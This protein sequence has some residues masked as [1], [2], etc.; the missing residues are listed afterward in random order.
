VEEYV[1]ALLA[2]AAMESFASENAARLATLQAARDSIDR[3]LEDLRSVERR[4]RQEQV[5]A[6]ILELVTGA[7][8]SV[9]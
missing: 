8:T 9:Q 7:A 1:F 3:A 5:T 6:E 2:H 4:L